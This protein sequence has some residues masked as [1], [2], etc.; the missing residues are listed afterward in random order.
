MPH[1]RLQPVNPKTAWLSRKIGGDLFC[2]PYWTMSGGR[3][4]QGVQAAPGNSQRR[5]QRESPGNRGTPPIDI[6]ALTLGQGGCAHALSTRFHEFARS[7]SLRARLGEAPR[8]FYHGRVPA[9][10]EKPPRP[11]PKVSGAPNPTTISEAYHQADANASTDKQK[12]PCQGKKAAVDF[13]AQ[14][15]KWKYLASKRG[16]CSTQDSG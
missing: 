1:I 12:L 2:S 5:W 3:N 15:R 10:P 4:C 9:S 8:P 13:P 16:H 7:S 14:S 11:R 6:W